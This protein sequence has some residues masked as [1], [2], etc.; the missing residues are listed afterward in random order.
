MPS[1][2]SSS[3]DV[4][5][6]VPPRAS[7]AS[8]ED[9]VADRDTLLRIGMSAVFVA[10]VVFGALRLGA[11]LSSGRVAPW[12]GNLGGAALLPLLYAWYRT[13]RVGR[14]SGAVHGTAL[15]ATVALTIPAA[16]GM[17]SSKWWLSLVGFSVM[18]MGRR[19]EALVWTAV[20]LVLVPLVA[21]TEGS[22]TVAGAIGEPPVERTMAGL[23][24]V[25][26][27]LAITWAFR[28]AAEDRARE[29]ARTAEALG[30]A[31]EVKSRFLAHMSHEIRTPLHGVIAMT[32][33]ALQDVETDP[34]RAQ[35]ATAAQSA[36]TLLGLL[37]NVLDVTRAESEALV[38]D[39]RPFH[40]HAALT[41]VLRP[42][43][44]QAHAKGLSFVA[45]A[46]AAI[47]A[48]RV[49][50]RI[51]VGQIVMNLVSNA[52][53][54]TKKGGITVRLA[55][56]SADRVRLTVSDTG[57][58]IPADRFTDIFEPFTQVSASD[59]RVLGGA[60][61]GLAIV[62]ELV[63]LMDGRVDVTSSLGK[64]ATFTAELELPCDKD[65]APGPLD[66]LL[67]LPDAE[68]AK[69]SPTHP[70]P[71]PEGLEVL[72]CED[73]VVNQTVLL[74]MLRRKGHRV[75]MTEDGLA[76][77]EVLQTRTFDLVITDV[78]M[79]GLTGIELA[80]RIRVD[81]AKRDGAR[82]PIIGATAHV[83]DNEQHQLLD[84]GMDAHLGKPFT[85]RELSLVIARVAPR[86][87][88]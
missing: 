2:A 50:D 71:E 15:I 9:I 20:T 48:A 25:A 70:D 77:W 78:E 43:E 88:R 72:V 66:L 23:F 86:L 83:G 4:T 5:P 12:W 21:L 47:V 56:A 81:E 84:A 61:L 55:A 69:T 67:A 75:T 24:F 31:N 17:T 60:G 45:R 35:I 27:L 33:L 32:D 29:L 82:V 51:R 18:L 26:I 62:R 80:Q 63:V 74:A 68:G 53:K 46:D 41:D 1:R 37:T 7:A 36:R 73:N 30:R 42:L 22:I 10:C 57:P 58:G 16:Y 79:P 65:E 14:S 3:R 38:L 49:G 28:R 13:D 39:P 54:F 11:Q 85:L 76:A 52:L 44:A 64:G 6:V 8:S 87:R 19:A 34:A 40:L 59:Q